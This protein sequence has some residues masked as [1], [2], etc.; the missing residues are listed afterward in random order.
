MSDCARGA[1]QRPNRAGR[2]PAVAANSR[3][4]ETDWDCSRRLRA[5]KTITSAVS[6]QAGSATS[7]QR[8]PCLGTARRC[9]PTNRSATGTEAAKLSPTAN[10]VKVEGMVRVTIIAAPNASPETASPTQMTV[11]SRCE[12]SLEP[13]DATSARLR[14]CG[15]RNGTGPC[16]AP[17]ARRSPFS[18]CRLDDGTLGG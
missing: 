10:L 12:T 14:R 8:F 4:T 13:L 2:S 7:Y 11:R 15:C 17:A 18:P 3:A 9:R 1:P 5:G 6:L 16:R